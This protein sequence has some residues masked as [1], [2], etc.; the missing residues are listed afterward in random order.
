V[1][2]VRVRVG[3][4]EWVADRIKNWFGHG[5]CQFRNGSGGLTCGVSFNWIWLLK[6]RCFSRS[7]FGGS[8][9]GQVRI[10]AI[11]FRNGLV[12]LSLQT[13]QTARLGGE[14]KR[15]NLGRSATITNV[16]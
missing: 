7:S 11:P 4:T 14:D 3:A 10:L 15:E 6:T 5:L 2:C 9:E 1:A 16:G 13:F 8:L 12:R